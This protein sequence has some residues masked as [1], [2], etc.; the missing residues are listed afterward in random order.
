MRLITILLLTINLANVFGQDL[1]LTKKKENTRSGKAIFT[2][3]ENNPS[4]KHGD[5]VVKAYTGKDK[6]VVGKYDHNKKTGNWTEKYYGFGYKGLKCVGEYKNDIKVGIWTYYSFKGDTAQIYN[7]STDKMIFAIRCKNDKEEYI[8][9]TDS[10]I[11]KTKLDFPPLYISGFD[12]FRDNLTASL[13][14]YPDE[15]K[16]NKLDY[17]KI[18]TDLTFFINKNGGIEDIKFSNSIGYGYEEQI[19]DFVINAGKWIAGVKDGEKV[20]AQISIPIKMSYQF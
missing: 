14:S 13:N 19:Q 4:I 17:F 18:D 2:V 8:V 10:E 9:K 15:L 16:T 6:I 11:V 20:T 5:Y 12:I 7:H 3:I 1:K